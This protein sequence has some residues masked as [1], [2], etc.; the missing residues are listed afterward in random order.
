MPPQNQKTPIWNNMAKSN[1]PPLHLLSPWSSCPTLTIYDLRPLQN[2]H[3]ANL[4]DDC[5]TSF[6][7]NYW[8]SISQKDHSAHIFKVW[9]FK[10]LCTCPPAIR[11]F[12]S[13][14]ACLIIYIG[15]YNLQFSGTLCLC[16]TFLDF[17]RLGSR[18]SSSRFALT[19]LNNSQKSSWKPL[20]LTPRN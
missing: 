1:L 5:P 18:L 12:S 19:A 9:C 15:Y 2:P 11:C 3:T 7:T 20:Y 6:S 10:Y 14:A 8:L 17:L 4:H 13:G 16:I